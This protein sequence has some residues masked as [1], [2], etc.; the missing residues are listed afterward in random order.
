ML[1]QRWSRSLQARI[2]P[3]SR[4]R[5]SPSLLIS[6]MSELMR[7]MISSTAQP[8]YAGKQLTALNAAAPSRSTTATTTTSTTS[9]VVLH[10]GCTHRATPPSARTHGA[11]QARS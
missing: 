7:A 3:T 9:P 4:S 6:F 1:T 10:A 2:P 11:R 5:V 8:A